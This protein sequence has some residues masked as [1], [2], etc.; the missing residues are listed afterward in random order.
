MWGVKFI[1]HNVFLVID[2]DDDVVKIIKVNKVGY[3]KPIMFSHRMPTIGILNPPNPI[4]RRKYKP[5]TSTMI[6]K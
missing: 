6:P 5:C 4:K 2:K 3:A 1:P